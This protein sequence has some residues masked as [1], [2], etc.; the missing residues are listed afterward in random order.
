MIINALRS[1]IDERLICMQIGLFPLLERSL[2]AFGHAPPIN[3]T[4]QTNLGAFLAG[5][6][7]D[8]IDSSALGA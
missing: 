4:P 2:L 7:V 1:N 3:A 5:L 6:H 8:G